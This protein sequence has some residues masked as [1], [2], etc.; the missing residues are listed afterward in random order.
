MINVNFKVITNNHN[1]VTIV[2]DGTYLNFFLSRNR[3]GTH[4]WVAFINEDYSDCY[5]GN[6]DCLE[7]FNEFFDSLRGVTVDYLYWILGKEGVRNRV[8]LLQLKKKLE[9]SAKMTRLFYKTRERNKILSLQ[10]RRKEIINEYL[11]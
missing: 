11:N 8:V 2:V 5:Q 9:S 10:E 1:N 7:L 6:N 3:Y 4:N